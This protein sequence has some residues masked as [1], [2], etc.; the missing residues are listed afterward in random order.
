M[1]GQFCGTSLKAIEV[2][3]EQNLHYEWGNQAAWTRRST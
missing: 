2:W 1:A 3:N